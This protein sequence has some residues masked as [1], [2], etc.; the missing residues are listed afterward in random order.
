MSVQQKAEAK[1]L[2]STKKLSLGKRTL[3]DLSVR[4]AGPKGGFITKNTL[5]SSPSTSVKSS[6]SARLY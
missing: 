1:A 4:H 6:I 2:D 5:A 3:K